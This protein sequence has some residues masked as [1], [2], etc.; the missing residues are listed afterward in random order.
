MKTEYSGNIKIHNTNKQIINS[1][2]FK[3]TY[4]IIENGTG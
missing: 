4:K 1:G 2:Y 3:V